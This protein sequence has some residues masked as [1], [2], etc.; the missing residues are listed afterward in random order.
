MPRTAYYA[1][2]MAVN[3][4]HVT[5]LR[6]QNN[7]DNFILYSPHYNVLCHYMT[8]RLVK[9]DSTLSTTAKNSLRKALKQVIK[10]YDMHVNML[11]FSTCLSMYTCKA[12]VL[13]SILQQIYYIV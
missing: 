4:S 7:H 10:I 8:K 3:S 9:S 1:A 6:R 5:M 11:S 13:L 2:T 12:S